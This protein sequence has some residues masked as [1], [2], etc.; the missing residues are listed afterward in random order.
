M[1]RIVAFTIC[2]AFVSAPAS[3]QQDVRDD[4]KAF[5]QG[6]A[7]GAANLA[8]NDAAAV[9]NLTGYN[10]P[11]APETQFLDNPAALEAARISA[12]RNNDAAVLVIDGDATRPRVPDELIDETIERGEIINEDPSIYV[13]GVDPNGTTGQ[14]VELPPTTSSPGNFEATCNVGKGIIDE[15]QTCEIPLD[16]TATQ[17]TVYDYQCSESGWRGLPK[18][19]HPSFTPSIGGICEIVSHEWVDICLQGT[20]D[21]CTEPDQ[22]QVFNLECSSPVPGEPVPTPRQIRNITAIPNETQCASIAANSNCSNPVQVCTDSS[23]QTRLINGV[24]VTQPCWRWERSYQCQGTFDGNDCGELAANSA[25][26]FSRSVC[27]DDPQQG[28]C[29]VEEHIYICPIPGAVPGEKQFVCG[30]DVYCI[31]GDCEAVTRE[32]SDEFK[33]AVV[34]LEALAQA[35]REF[36]EVDY[37]LFEGNP[38]SCHKPIFGLVNCC[39]GKVSGLIPTAAG[40]AA[41]AGGPTAIAGLATPFLTLFLCDASEKEL[42]VRERMGLCHTLGTYCSKKFLGICTTKRRTSCCFLSKLTRVL[43]EQ[44]REQLSKSWGTPKETECSGFTID[45]FAALDLSVMDFTEVYQEFMDAAKLPN[46]AETMTDIQGKIEAYYS[47][48]GP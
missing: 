5:A 16:V 20:L 23:P 14:C 43:Q 9:D 39:A 2:L 13:Q 38:M 41:L 6:L 35:N 12:A 24:E 36:S 34:G 45:E 47:R 30:G 21:N 1:R 37:K 3:A 28:D 15:I 19:C 32:A 40:F 18:V 22:V 10:G 7:D 29:Q 26:Q 44:G 42:D 11:N 8:D 33:D 25:C 48:G 17:R 31:G 46:E 4:A 27:L